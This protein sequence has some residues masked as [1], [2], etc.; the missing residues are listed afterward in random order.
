[1]AA[2]IPGSDPL[3]KGLRKQ[4]RYRDFQ[5]PHPQA[6]APSKERVLSYAHFEGNTGGHGSVGGGETE[7]YRLSVLTVHFPRVSDQRGA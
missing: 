5:C 6:N 1:M 3:Q 7:G 4:L 2:A